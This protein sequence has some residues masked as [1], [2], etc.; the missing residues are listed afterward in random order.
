MHSVN[1]IK[2]IDLVRILLP[3]FT[4]LCT[5]FA[6]VGFWRMFRKWN[7][8]GYLSL[9][10]FA[11]GWIFARDSRKTPRLV[12]TI[13]D[14][15]VLLMTPAFYYFSATGRTAAHRFLGYTIYMDSSLLVLTVIWC[16][17]QACVF[18]SSIFVSRR[19]C[20]VNET[21]KFWMICWI[22]V[23][24]LTKIIWGFSEKYLKRKTPAV[25]TS[26]GQDDAARNKNNIRNEDALRRDKN[27]PD[28]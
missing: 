9:L 19:L 15:I 24:N 11:R 13:S 25:Q 23:P 26:S 6:T 1:M 10:P 12:Y 8:P 3:Y 17:L 7:Q 27:H 2:L 16:I 18:V 20:E 21:N 22:L 28:A 4:A 5:I 14:G